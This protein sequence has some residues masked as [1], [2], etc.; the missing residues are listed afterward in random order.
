[1]KV[2]YGYSSEH[3]MKLVMI[4]S[5]K[6]EQDAVKTASVIKELR[7]ELY[8]KLEAGEIDNSYSKEVYEMLNR[9]GIYNLS[10]YD[11]NQFLFDFGIVQEGNKITLKTDE[12]E[13]SAFFKLMVE[14][15]AKIE[16][17]STHDYPLK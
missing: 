12:S 1:M 8:D 15:G 3:S 14:N 2:W 16:M 6:S 5:F 11:L 9:M 10:T 7:E 13:V 17:F 4:G